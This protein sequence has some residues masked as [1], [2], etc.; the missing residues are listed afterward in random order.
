MAAGLWDE[1][2]DLRGRMRGEDKGGGGR[3]SRDCGA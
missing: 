1:G 3:R 2:S